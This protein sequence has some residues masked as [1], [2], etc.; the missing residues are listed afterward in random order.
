[1]DKLDYHVFTKIVTKNLL[2]LLHARKKF[3]VFLDLNNHCSIDEA[4]E[5][6]FDIESLKARELLLDEYRSTA[7]SFVDKKQ[8]EEA[9]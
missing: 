5:A 6:Q 8:R 7:Q 4:L 1:M 3:N 2:I 9:R